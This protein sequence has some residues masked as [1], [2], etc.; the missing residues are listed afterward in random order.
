MTDAQADHVA[1]ETRMA[2]ARQSL[3]ATTGSIEGR[4]YATDTREPIRDETLRDALIPS[5]AVKE[6]EGLSTTSP[7]PRYSLA[8]EFA[9]LLD[10]ALGDEELRSAVEAWQKANL[11]AAALARVAIVRQGAVATPEGVLVQSPN[12]ETRRMAPGPSSVISK[13]VIEEF[14]PR[15]LKDPGVIW[16]SESRNQVVARDNKL[17]Q[18]IGL[19]IQPDRNLP[20]IILVDL[21]PPLLV[22]VEAVA[23]AGP[24]SESRRG[25]LLAI[26]TEAG[27]NEHHT[28]FVTAYEDRDHPSFKR[29][30]S[31]LA[32]RSFAWFVSEPDK[33]VVL[34]EGG[35][36]SQ[37]LLSELL[38]GGSRSN[39]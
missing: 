4:W 35:N 36:G 27:F 31:S 9:A 21:E 12:R 18:A 1:D 24:I 23:T 19:T 11:S 2:W 25:S 37:S 39:L 8:P 13:A 38:D 26:A 33:I 14:A 29:T 3:Q 22:F 15:F 28:A 32:W 20:D 5:G 6:R 10:P 30:A 7:K 34:Q 17:A 16:L